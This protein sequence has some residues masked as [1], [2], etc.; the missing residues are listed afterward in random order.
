MMMFWHRL[1]PSND[2]YLATFAQATDC[3]QIL[4]IWLYVY[5]RRVED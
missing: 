5:K 3:N 1:A 2:Q 4:P